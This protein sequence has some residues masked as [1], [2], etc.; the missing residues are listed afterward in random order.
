MH[1][2]EEAGPAMGIAFVRVATGIVELAC[3]AGAGARLA[4]RCGDRYEATTMEGKK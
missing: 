4:N 1:G 2:P 3:G